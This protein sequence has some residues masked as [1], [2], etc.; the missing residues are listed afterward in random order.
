VASIDTAVALIGI[1]ALNRLIVACGVSS[2]FDQVPGIDLRTFWRDAL[3]AAVAANKLAPA[4]GANPEE[5]YV[6]GLLHAAGHLILCQSYPEIANAMFT[7]FAPARG[8]ELADIET[9][10]FGI[11]HP[12]VGALW[13]ESIGFPKSVAV[14]IGRTALEPAGLCE[15]LDLALNSACSLAA[16]VAQGWTA[17]AALAALPASVGARFTTA[18]GQADAA[19]NRLY[20]VLQKAE[21]M[22]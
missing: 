12:A 7:G 9:Q 6:C 5:A 14:A 21:P 22:L 18:N 13:V 19:F 2:A 4:L 17:D 16:A 20:E 3:V 1:Q 10:A 15:P 11:D 8:A